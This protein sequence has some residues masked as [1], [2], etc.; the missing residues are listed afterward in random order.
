MLFPIIYDTAN[1]SLVSR[2]LKPSNI[3]NKKNLWPAP[4]D[5]TS[6]FELDFFSY[7]CSLIWKGQE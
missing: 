3:K 5:Y 6:G 7:V 4:T 2:N 1:L